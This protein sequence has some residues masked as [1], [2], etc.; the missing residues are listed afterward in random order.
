MRAIVAIV[1]TLL[2]TSVFAAKAKITDVNFTDLGREGKI[3]ITLDKETNEFPVV[4]TKSN[5]VQVALPGSFVWPKIE[6]KFT[7]SNA[8]DSKLMAYQFNKD[9]VRVRAF[10]PGNVEKLQDR[11]SMVLKG[12]KVIVSFPKEKAKVAVSPVKRKPAVEK[13]K[14]VAVEKYDESYLDKLLKEKEQA[15]ELNKPKEKSPQMAA[16]DSGV[17]ED[18]VNMALAANKKDDGGFNLMTYIG[19]FVGFL[20][21][22]LLLFYGVVSLLK[23]GALKKGKLGFLNS[24]KVVEVLNTTYIGPK[25]SLLMI[26]AH[27][28]VFLVGSSEKGLHMISEL[29]DVNGLFKEGEKQISG[30]NFD[31]TLGTAAGQNKEFKLKEFLSEG[32]E[33]E[34]AESSIALQAIE[35]EMKAAKNSHKAKFSDQIKNKIKDLKPLQ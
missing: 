17:T 3:I 32:T 12:K 34:E 7:Y 2:T 19:K 11:L 15:I 9:L 6:K 8:F 29:N 26:R 25:R 24:T 30:S 22:V 23:K 35:K 10:I 28:Q 18:T 31:S 20:A 14:E 1:A 27:K 5:F 13:A 16:K 33:Q 4:T 21:L